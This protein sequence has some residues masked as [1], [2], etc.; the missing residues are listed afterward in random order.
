MDLLK[1]IVLDLGG[2]VLA[3]EW[4]QEQVLWEPARSYPYVW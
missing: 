3:A 1:D 4:L 2:K